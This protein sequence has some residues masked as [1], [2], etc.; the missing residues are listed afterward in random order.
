MARLIFITPQEMSQTTIMGGNVDVDKYINCIDEVQ[1]RII[2]R[3]LG[4]ELYDKLITDLTPS[5]FLVEDGNEQN[6]NNG[7]NLIIATLHTENL[8]EPYRSLFFDYVKPI[9]KYESL[10]SYIEISVFVLSNRGLTKPTSENNSSPTIKEIE[11]LSEKQSSKAQTYVNEF[12]KWIS[13]NKINIPEYKTNQEG[14]NAE[15]INTNNGWY[16]ED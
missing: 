7:N 16:M 13:Q 14:V 6:I 15:Q 4:G 3:L 2:K 8:I 1:I 12:E 5:E 11:W 9:T 10:A